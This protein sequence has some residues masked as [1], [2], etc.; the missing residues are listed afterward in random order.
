MGVEA[1]VRGWFEALFLVGAVVATLLIF[2]HFEMSPFGREAGPPATRVRSIPP[3]EPAIPERQEPATPRVRSPQPA[4]DSAA[5]NQQ[6]QAARDRQTLDQLMNTCRYWSS[7][8]FERYQQNMR[9]QACNRAL[10]FAHDKQLPRPSIPDSSAPAPI[11]QSAPRERIVING[12][13]CTRYTVGS[14]AYRECRARVGKSL[15]DTC[16]RLT[17]QSLSAGPTSPRLKETARA[18]CDAADRY[19]IVR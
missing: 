8:P 2:D 13:D 12:D 11:R 14:I 3:R 19:K 15:Q 4:I 6:R 7:Q 17:S 1:R 5:I 16:R 9:V 18:Y 10:Q